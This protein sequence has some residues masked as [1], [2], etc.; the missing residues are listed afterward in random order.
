[1]VTR[2][3]EFPNSKGAGRNVSEPIN[4]LVIINGEA[5]PVDV[6]GR[7][8]DKRWNNGSGGYRLPG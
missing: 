2:G 7:P 8:L 6:R 1:M 3:C 4:S 5:D